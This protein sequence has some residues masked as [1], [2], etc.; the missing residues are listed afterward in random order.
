M[1]DVLPAKLNLINQNNYL[2][3]TPVECSVC[4]HT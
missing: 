1:E 3:T 2:R 4:I